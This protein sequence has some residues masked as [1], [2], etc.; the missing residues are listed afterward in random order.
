MS[1]T[2][3]MQARQFVARGAGEC[4]KDAL[5]RIVNAVRQ[6]WYSWYAKLPLFRFVQE[7]FEVQ[8]FPVDCSRCNETYLGITL[9][10]DYDNVEALWFD[11]RRVEI[12]D[13]WRQ[14]QYGMSQPCDCRLESFDMGEFATE[15]D[16]LLG[17]PKRIGFSALDSRDKGKR[18]AIQGLTEF[19]VPFKQDYHLTDVPQYTA[20]ALKSL[21]QQGGIVKDLTVG[22]V[23]VS[24]EGGRVLSILAPDE[25]IPTYRRIKITGLPDD[26]ANVNVRAARRFTMLYDDFD[27]VET[28]NANAW[29][30]MARAQRIEGKPQKDG[31]DLQAIKADKALAMGLLSGDLS[32]KEGKSVRADLRVVSAPPFRTFRRNGWRG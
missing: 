5:T 16:I 4:D 17:C 1:F 14:W 19:G 20:P 9:P 29:E 15:R 6:E 27:V 21:K 3:F 18:F 28:D 24:E 31:A 11:G 25:T 30:A 23:V 8:T 2:L 32:R 26:C 10:R 13:R 7:C 22:R 12:F